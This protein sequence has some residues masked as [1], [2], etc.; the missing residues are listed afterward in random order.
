MLKSTKGNH[1]GNKIKVK[2]NYYQSTQLVKESEKGEIKHYAKEITVKWD[3]IYT[4]GI[5]PLAPELFFEILAHP[6]Y[7]M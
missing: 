6:A 3:Q 1:S 4:K 2:I 7:K 5:N